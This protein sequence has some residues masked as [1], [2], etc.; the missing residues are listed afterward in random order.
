[1]DENK[2]PDTQP[3]PAGTEAPEGNEEPTGADTTPQG[4]DGGEQKPQPKQTPEKK[5]SKRERLEHAKS[6]IENQLDELDEEDED[7][8]L[9]VGEYKQMKRDESRD[10]AVKL[11][12]SI[13]DED[14][15]NEVIDLLQ[16]RITP[17]GDPNQDLNLA[18]GA[19]NS[20]KNA[21]IAEETERKKH[22]A[23]HPSGPGA[24]AGGA[25]DEFTPTAEES[26][27][28]RPPFNM[29]KDD[30]LNARKESQEKRAQQN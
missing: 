24:P 28:M 27:F 17:S 20:L 25:E 9:T 29:T 12:E 3:E 13:E 21:Q 11:A 14:E 19:V 2:K 18:R 10:D 1:M 6:K 30:I 7:R 16:N 4:S 15:R 22:P 23:Q 5:F 8:P 26:R